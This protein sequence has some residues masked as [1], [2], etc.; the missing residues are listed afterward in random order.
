MNKIIKKLGITEY[1]TK[2]IIKAKENQ[3]TEQV[4]NVV[5]IDMEPRRTDT[6]L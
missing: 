1:E 6:L 3:R 5:C 2:L 4:D